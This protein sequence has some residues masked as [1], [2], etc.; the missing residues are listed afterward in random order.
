MGSSSAVLQ[1]ASSLTA[2]PHQGTPLSTEETQMIDTLD[3]SP[4]R[5]KKKPIPE[6]Y[7]LSDPI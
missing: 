2:R 3:E 7:V 4:V 1:R 6:A 5:G